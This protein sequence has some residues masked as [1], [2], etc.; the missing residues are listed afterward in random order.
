MRK[1]LTQEV[2]HLVEEWMSEKNDRPIEEITAGSGYKAWWKCKT[3]DNQWQARIVLRVKGSNCP[4]CAGKHGIPFLAGAP[5][6]AK[7]WMSEKN[8]RPIE[9]ITSGS[10]YKAWWKCKTCDNQWQAIVQNRVNKRGCPKCSGR[11]GFPLIEKSP[12]LASEWITDRNDRSL[13]EIT[14]GSGYKAWWKCKTCEH[15]WQA[16]VQNRVKGN[17]CPECYNLRRKSRNV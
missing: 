7:E 4:Q 11:N 16:K 2:P 14:S 15:Q 1:K 8:D 9:K 10:G 13:E 17:G 12:H 5:H 6:L 3:C